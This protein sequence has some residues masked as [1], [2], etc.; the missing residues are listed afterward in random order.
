MPNYK[1]HIAGGI[2][3]YIV[4]LVLASYLSL[5]VPLHLGIAGVSCL[6]GALFPD[7]DVKSRGQNLF[8]LG[9]FI[10][11]GY[12]FLIGNMFNAALLGFLSLVPMVVRH[13]GLF[14]RLWFVAGIACALA[15]F[16]H[17]SV[18]A[19]TLKSF[20]AAFFFSLG[21]LSHIWLDMGFKSLFR[22]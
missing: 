7:V 11:V 9:I 10:I 21:A 13:R 16:V 5:S 2:A 19:Y 8:Y 18:P 22:L 4:V 15:F 3:A 20:T 17:L 12:F 1:G 14:H 6:A